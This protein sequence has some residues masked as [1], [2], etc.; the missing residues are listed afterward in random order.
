MTRLT[1]THENAQKQFVHVGHTRF[2][3]RCFGRAGEV[4]LVFLNYFAADMDDWDPNRTPRTGCGAKA[5]EHHLVHRKVRVSGTENPSIV[6]HGGN[7][8]M[9]NRKSS[10][11][12]NNP[13]RIL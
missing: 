2:A 10:S 4:P 3:H 5:S 11:N 12:L 9:P 1:E 6:V 7:R 13:R 8:L